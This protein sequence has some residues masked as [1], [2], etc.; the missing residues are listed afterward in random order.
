MDGDSLVTVVFNCP[1]LEEGSPRAMPSDRFSHQT[2]VFPKIGFSPKMDGENN[3]K[4]YKNGMIW[5]YPYFRKHLN[6]LPWKK[7]VHFQT[8]QYQTSIEFHLAYGNRF[9]TAPCFMIFPMKGSWSYP[10]C[11]LRLPNTEVTFFSLFLEKMPGCL[12][13]APNNSTQ[14]NPTPNQSTHLPRTATD[15]PHLNVSL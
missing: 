1:L 8:S 11:Y 2:S 14:I 4:P 12:P 15:R 10:A 13:R 7:L 6:Q 3:G 9:R 5:G